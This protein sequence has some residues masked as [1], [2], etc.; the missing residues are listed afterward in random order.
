VTDEV[1]APPAAAVEP[2]P[3]S[4]LAR[5]ASIAG[6]VIAI[7]FLL[8]VAVTV[9][10][11]WLFQLPFYLAFGW[12]G[13]LRENAATL[14]PNPRLLVE[15]LLC[16]IALGVGTHY[17]CRWL[18]R[19]VAPD[20]G[21]AWRARWTVMGLGLLFLLFAAGIG[22]IGLTH[23]VAWLIGAKAPL[24]QDT[25]TDRARASEAILH[26]S[27]LRTQVA[28]HFE[29]TGK[30]PDA[31]DPVPPPDS[32]RSI[33][34]SLSVAQGGIITITLKREFHGGGSIKFSPSVAD[35]NL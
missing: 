21:G 33:L 12:F 1:T 19:A 15:A 9:L 17:F 31:L 20:A 3:R 10:E 25:F 2:A 35:C 14:Q 11:P 5:A 6:K 13:F 27:G 30:L 4:R 22:T 16:V 23:Q 32:P 26:A 29:R 18:Y 34:E 24:V 7:L 8:V 28:E